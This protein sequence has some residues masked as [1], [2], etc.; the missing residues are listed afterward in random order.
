MKTIT[1]KILG[2][3]KVR[4]E[5][6]DWRDRELSRRHRCWGRQLYATDLDFV[7]AGD[8]AQPL[9]IIETKATDFWR[10]DDYSI[11]IQRNLADKAELPFFVVRRYKNYDFDV[12]P[13]NSYALKFLSKRARLSEKEFIELQ[14]YL[15]FGRPCK[16]TD[17]AYVAVVRKAVSR[18]PTE[19]S[20]QTVLFK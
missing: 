18:Q 6:S 11:K 7:E 14:Y 8:D 15:R 10:Y 2:L 12:H 4:V 16:L 5:R 9:A 3:E 13:M 19:D 1:E 17:E 20:D